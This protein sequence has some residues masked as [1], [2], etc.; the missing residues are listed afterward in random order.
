MT[1][2][3]IRQLS[4]I[5]LLAACIAVS[6]TFKLPGIFPGSEFQ[7]SAPLAVAICGVFGA[8]KYLLAGV[9]ASAVGLL[10]GT[11]TIFNVCIAMLF[12]A[13]VAILYFH[14]GK[15]KI[16]YIIAGP[17][18]SASARLAL[19]LLIGKAVYPLLLSAVPGMIFTSLTASF[20]AAAF[21]KALLLNHNT[22]ERS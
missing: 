8:K 9:L 16:F 13:V 10:L 11:A 3:N 6:G 5:A 18:A 20:F 21:K 7:L 17:L 15:T 12:R 19:G 2:N 22:C 1:T 4:E 14:F